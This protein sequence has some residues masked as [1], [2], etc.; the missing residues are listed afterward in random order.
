MPFNQKVR[1]FFF[2]IVTIACFLSGRAQAYDS[3]KGVAHVTIKSRGIFLDSEQ[4]VMIG[5][6]QARLYGLDELGGIRYQVRVSG[7]NIEIYFADG[8]TSRASKLKKI[9]KLPL[10]QSDFLKILGYDLPDHFLSEQS[11]NVVV[12]RHKKKKR[13]RV[14]FNDFESLRNG[15]KYPKSILITYKKRYIKF[16]WLTVSANSS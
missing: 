3:V 4:V 16:E 6:N 1:T 9:L 15:R 13:L 5:R 12:W 7:S 11:G 8:G 14:T 10:E 2:A